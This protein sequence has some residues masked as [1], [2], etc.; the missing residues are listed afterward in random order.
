MFQ[1]LVRT[2]ISIVQAQITTEFNEN[3]RFMIIAGVKHQTLNQIFGFYE[4]RLLKRDEKKTFFHQ[5]FLKM[6]RLSRVAFR[7]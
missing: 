5:N 1:K 4:E 3:L 2:F 7:A 6:D